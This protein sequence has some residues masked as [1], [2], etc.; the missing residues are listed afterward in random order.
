MNSR[1]KIGIVGYGNLGKGV[2]KSLQQNP[3]MELKAIFSRRSPDYFSTTSNI[4]SMEEIPNFKD[5]IDVMI[6]CGGSAKDLP[7]QSLEIAQYF[8]TVDSFDTHAEIPQYF[9]A[10]NKIA[11]QN[12]NLSLISTGWDPGLFSIIRVLGESILPK[13]KTYTFWGE[14]LS[15]GHSDAV[16]QIPGVKLAAQYTLPNQQALREAKLKNQPDL[17]IPSMHN[18]KVYVV[19]KE[20][21]CSK[22]I[23]KAIKTMPHYFEPY[24]TEVF[25][26]EEEEFL[27]NHQNMPHGGQVIRT[28]FSQENHFQRMEFLL[29][30]EN[31][32]AF[33]SS[34]LVAFARAVFR[35]NQE[36]KIG[37][38]SVFD[39]PLGLL[40]PRSAED[41]RK[42]F[43]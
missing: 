16:R 15:Q 33:T 8:S 32:P 6:L 42:T 18:R 43:L 22:E 20:N 23:E 38:I 3:D 1:I 2:E 31:N 7:V 30:L 10:V 14:G 26:I 37:A 40:S 19:L 35:M 12:K 5:K 24:H 27:K 11:T 34:V 29:Q 21:F 25:F 28:G 13:G 9:E 39:V 41:L 4:L 17:D 36:N